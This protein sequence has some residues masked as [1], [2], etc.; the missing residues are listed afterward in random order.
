MS[1]A[2]IGDQA[3]VQGLAL[4]GARVLAVK[5]PDQARRAW[6]D[7]D[8]GVVLV[9]LTAEVA[10]AIEDLPEPGLRLRLVLP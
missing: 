2:V 4:A 9:L 10:R 8:Q 3:R 1:V 7:L 5:S 6:L